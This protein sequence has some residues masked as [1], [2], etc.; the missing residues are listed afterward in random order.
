[1]LGGRRGATTGQVSRNDEARPRFARKAERFYID[2]QVFLRRS[3][4]LNVRVRG[5][6]VS[7]FGCKIEFVERPTLDERVWIK[8]DGLGSLEGLVCWVDGFV[9]GIEFTQAIHP[10]VFESLMPRLR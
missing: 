2:A 9:A 5:F 3:G 7:R 8:F 6:D 4:K 10:A 1:M